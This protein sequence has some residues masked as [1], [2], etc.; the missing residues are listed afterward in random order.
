MPGINIGLESH[1]GKTKTQVGV[2]KEQRVVI[3]DRF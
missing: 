1:L 3:I 2:V